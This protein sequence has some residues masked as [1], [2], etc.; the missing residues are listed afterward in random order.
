MGTYGVD[1]ALNVHSTILEKLSKF[2]L[3]K[4]IKS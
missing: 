1:T 2:D 3:I 4:E